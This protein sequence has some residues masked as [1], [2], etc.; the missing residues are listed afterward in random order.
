VLTFYI[1]L[2][3]DYKSLWNQNKHGTFLN[4]GPQ[5]SFLIFSSPSVARAMFWVWQ[6]SG[7]FHQHDYSKLLCAHI[8]KAQKDIQNTSVFLRFWDLHAQN[9]LVKQMWNWPL[10]LFSQSFTTLLHSCWYDFAPMTA[11]TCFRFY[12]YARI[13]Y[14]CN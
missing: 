3:I 2:K 11:Y 5:V 14:T 8:P 13:N 6:A 10:S 7:R 1:L 12:V 9:L 4:C